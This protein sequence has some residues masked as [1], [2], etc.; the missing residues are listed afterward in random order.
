MIPIA[1][2]RWSFAASIPLMIVCGLIW[3]AAAALSFENWRRRGRNR[4][5][6]FLETLRM[7][8]I[9]L[10]CVTLLKPEIIRETNANQRPEVAI[11]FD[12]SGSMHTRDVTM[13]EDTVLER[14][15]WVAK[16]KEAK[17]WAPIERNAAVALEDF[18]P[19]P[20]EEAKSQEE[21]GTDINRALEKVLQREHRLKAVLLISDGDWNLGKSPVSAATRFRTLNVPVFT[22]ATGSEKPLPDIALLNVSAPS[23]GLLGEQVSIPFKIQNYF[24]REVKTTVSLQSQGIE[25]ARKDVVLPPFGLVQDSLV[26][27]PQD[28]GEFP[29]TVK[30]PVEKEESLTDNNE[31]NFRMSVRAEKLNVL[32]VESSPR[33]EYRFLRNALARDPG[34]DMQCL[35]LHPGLAPGDGRNYI[36]KFP[37]NKEALS[38]FDV[39]FLGDVGIGPKELT[40]EDAERIK[41]L[42]EQQGSGLV[43][44]P[45]AAG[46]E[47]TLT[48]SAL[49]DL[50]PVSFDTSKPKG[51][52]LPTQSHLNLTGAGRG[53]LLTML[54][55][56]ED[57][58]QNVWKNLP[59][60][61]WCAAVEK[62]RPGSEVLAVHS[63]L[64]N[65]W[66]RMPL[67]VTRPY[68]NGKVLFMGTDGAWR[69]RR[70]VEDKYHYRFWGQVVRWMAHQRHLAQGVGIRLTYSPEDPRAGE[71]VYMQA[72]VLDANG[73]PVE[74]GLVS[75]SI[76]APT[77]NQ[78][79]VEFSS[80]QGGWG[81][82]KSSFVPSVGGAY[83]VRLA[84]EEAGRNLET[85]II[86]TRPNRE[87]LGQPANVSAMREM[88]DITR[89]ESGGVA[90]LPAILKKIL[91]L[92]EPQP[93]EKRI[94][95]WCNPWWGGAILLVFALY[96][97][98]R[99][100]AG[101]I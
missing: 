22:I 51:V 28:L 70:G 81:V 73:Y 82:F 72:T 98:F 27:S 76:K 61:Y 34:V 65:A 66:G 41:G 92:P 33:W 26:W 1:L 100:L 68:G 84:C 21:E 74:K 96:W 18:S 43:F 11:L 14:R 46:R 95:L 19:P 64:R 36:Q 6:L 89:G 47:L 31:Q 3:I 39:V 35:L 93:I 23:Y 99:K 24:N 86:V 38:K 30:L 69:W 77:G 52:A 101:M 44:L 54:A 71:T 25:V 45:G 29:L 87:K 13:E 63:S 5:T 79:N 49:N 20:G 40:E 78:E 91:V 37:D 67:L 58:N 12:A 8:A 83:K 57:K 15:E 88:A 60:F 55:A 9:T 48:K 97:T 59:G 4:V 85:E 56:D 75:G 53:H 7:V 42:V 16:Q 80:V 10:L 2:L 50:L 90:D 17:F 94:R 62:N 32:V